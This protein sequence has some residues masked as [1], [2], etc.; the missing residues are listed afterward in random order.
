VQPGIA[1]QSD[2]VVELKH[3]GVVPLQIGTHEHGEEVLLMQLFTSVSETQLAS[4]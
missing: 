1:L 3:D 4:F 2:I